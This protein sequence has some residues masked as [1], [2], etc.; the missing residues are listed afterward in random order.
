LLLHVDLHIHVDRE[1]EREGGRERERGREYLNIQKRDIK[2]R[3]AHKDNIS[4]FLKSSTN[5]GER[6]M[7]RYLSIH[8][9]LFSVRVRLSLSLPL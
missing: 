3:E 5:Q 1:R 4:F 9:F 2:A 6:E 8:F 7:G